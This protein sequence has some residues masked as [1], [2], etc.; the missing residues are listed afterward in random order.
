MPVL[1]EGVRARKVGRFF[2]WD[3]GAANNSGIQ[4][5]L[6]FS[7]ERRR[8]VGALGLDPA[9]RAGAGKLAGILAVGLCTVLGVVIGFMLRAS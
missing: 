6:G 7:H 9:T 1:P 4:W 3:G 5:V 8:L 2:N